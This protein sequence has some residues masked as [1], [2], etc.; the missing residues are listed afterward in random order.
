MSNRSPISSILTLNGPIL[1]I[2]EIFLV[3]QD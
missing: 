2:V 1:S 3:I